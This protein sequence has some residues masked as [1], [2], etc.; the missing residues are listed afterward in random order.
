MTRA[1]FQP[2]GDEA[3]GL[4]A[5]RKPG[6][7]ADDYAGTLVE[8]GGWRIVRCKHDIQWIVQK[9]ARRGCAGRDPSPWR[10]VAYIVNERFLREVISR[11]SL[12]VPANTLAVLLA[13]LPEHITD[14]AA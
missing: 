14:R 3:G 7:T 4:A 13:A 5:D 12:G 2:G 10:G 11:P 1:I 8:F 9:D 6:E